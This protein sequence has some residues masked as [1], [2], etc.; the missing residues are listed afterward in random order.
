MPGPLIVVP[1]DCPKPCNVPKLTTT[2]R[3]TA[4]YLIFT[5]PHNRKPPSRG[6]FLYP[7]HSTLYTLLSR[8]DSL[9]IHI[10]VRVHILRIIQVVDGLQ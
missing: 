10:E 5:Y 9:F 2:P 6:G 8:R 1:V 4:K 3:I 7:L